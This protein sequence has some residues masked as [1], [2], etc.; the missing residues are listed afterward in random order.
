MVTDNNI[1]Q[2]IY[3]VLNEFDCLITD[4]SSI[5]FD[6][7]LTDKPII[8]APFDF[9]W[10]I[11]ND[12]ELY[13]DYKK[14]TPGPTCSNWKEVI[15]SIKVIKDNSHKYENELSELKMKFH[16]YHDKENC[17]RVFDRISSLRE[18]H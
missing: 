8:F 3:T 9:K 14:V 16:K 7:L 18:L 2:D 12:R 15:D 13:F 6:F 17:K 10:Y 11:S 4:Y 1:E 5:Y